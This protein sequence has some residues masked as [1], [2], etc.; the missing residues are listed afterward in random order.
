MPPER[1]QAYYEDLEREPIVNG[2]TVD[3]EPPKETPLPYRTISILVIMR[4]A[5]PIN[6]T[7]I[8]PYVLS[9]ACPSKVLLAPL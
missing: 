9:R 1:T 8:F 4:V 6:F 5:E 7:M 3:H 2:A